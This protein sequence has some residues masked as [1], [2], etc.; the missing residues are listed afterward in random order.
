MGFRVQQLINQRP[1]L[2]HIFLKMVIGFT[3]LDPKQCRSLTVRNST[4]TNNDNYKFERYRTTQYQ[5]V[6][7][8]PPLL[9]HQIAKIVY[10]LMERHSANSWL[11]DAIDCI[12]DFQVSL[13]RMTFWITV[14]PEFFEFSIFEVVA[15]ITYFLK[16]LKTWFARKHYRN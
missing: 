10:D 3:T 13:I 15:A 16:W 6:D 14:T 11:W 4:H 9:A 7:A 5:Q 2:H 12:H 8:V 1:Q